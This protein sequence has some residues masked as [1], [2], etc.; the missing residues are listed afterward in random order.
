M[1]IETMDLKFMDTKEII[2]SFLLTGE[3]SVAII[4]TGPTTCVENL[5]Q[6]LKDRGVSPEDVEKVFLTHVHLDHAGAS[7]NLTELLPNATFCVHEVGYPHLVDPSTL[8]KS[9]TRIYGEE[10]MEEMWGEV[11]AVPEDRLEKLEGGEG[12]E[13][14]G[15]GFRG[16]HTPREAEHRSY[17]QTG[18][19]D[20]LPYAFRLIPGHRE[21]PERIGTTPAGVAPLHRGTYRRRAFPGR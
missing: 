13:G 9:A 3:G 16:G 20:P 10:S 21:A 18:A 12:I 8:V 17:T 15:G 2:A 4:E 14:A 6:G 11:R 7:G 1:K 19:G 5:M